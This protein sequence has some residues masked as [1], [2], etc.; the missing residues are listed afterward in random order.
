MDNKGY[1][2]KGIDLRVSNVFDLTD[3]PKYL[4]TLITPIIGIHTKEDYLKMSSSDNARIFDMIHYAE[5]FKIKELIEK[6]KTLYNKE[7]TAFFNE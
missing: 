4:E 5:A 3:D 7:L 1:I 2:Y 6:L